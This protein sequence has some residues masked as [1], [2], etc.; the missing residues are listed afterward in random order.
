MAI[1]DGSAC[2]VTGA[3]G[4]VGSNIVRYLAQHGR[5][6]LAVDFNPPDGLTRDYLRGLEQYVE[7]ST[8]DLTD[9]DAV[10]GLRAK[11]DIKRII[12]AAV[13]TATSKELEQ[14]DPQRILDSN[15]MGTV[16]VLELA[17]TAHTER[18]VYVSSSGLYPGNGDV[19]TP[20]TEDSIAPYLRMNSFYSITKIASEKLAQRYAEIFPP[21]T[22][23][24]MRIGAPY[25]CM[26]RPNRARTIM[27]PI[28][29]LLKLLITDKKKVL[30]VK[31]TS[32]I[33]DWTYAM[34]IA[35]GLVAG[36]EAPP[37]SP[38]YNLSCGENV[39]MPQI[40][41]AIQE[42]GVDFRWEAV[43][44][45]KDA[46]FVGDAG[47]GQMRGP[48]SMVKTR[49]ETGFSPKYSLAA[50]VKEYCDWWER[51]TSEGLWLPK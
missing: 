15:L 30:K 9:H 20:V 46:D 23:A 47:V 32:Y 48:L 14:S 50:G 10:V 17:R 12:H 13:F 29:R 21:L 27:G 18:V 8:M 49:K 42:A 5:R 26:E 45:Q 16:N 4:F 36:L 1:D 24:T 43:Q 44:D 11:H 2:L 38:L 28:Y 34:D 35:A 25:G 33:R 19:N 7:W 37:A 39:T 40:F 31:G 41:A 3:T 6:V 51:V 22:T